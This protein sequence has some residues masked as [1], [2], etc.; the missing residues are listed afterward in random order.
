[1][2]SSDK[3]IETISQL[4]EMV[5]HNIELRK[6]YT[7]LDIVEKVVRL[8]TMFALAM[9][10]IVF[11]SAILLFSSASF[12]VWLSK[13]IE[14][15]QSLFVVAGIYLLLLVIGYTMRSSWIERPLVKFLSKLLLN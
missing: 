9:L 2:L 7:K 6:E 3:N 5:K 14:L 11:I 1:M 13:F 15:Y 12:A 10:L 4:I 8:L